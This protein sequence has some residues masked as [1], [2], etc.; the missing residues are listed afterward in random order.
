MRNRH[1]FN[2]I[3]LVLDLIDNS[4]LMTDYS[5]TL[6]LD[7]YKALDTDEHAFIFYCLEKFGFGNFFK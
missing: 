1:I 2:N 4:D 5:F 6:C 3:G 7:F